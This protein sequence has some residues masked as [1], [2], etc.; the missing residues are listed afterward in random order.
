MTALLTIPEDTRAGAVLAVEVLPCRVE[1]TPDGPPFDVAP[2]APG[3]A[4]FWTVYTR[5]F[6]VPSRCGLAHAESDHPTPFDALVAA[7]ALAAEHGV[8]ATLTDPTTG[9]TVDVRRT[10]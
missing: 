2:C 8:P 5:R 1:T 6:D 4:E 10:A 3:E 7:A 9:R